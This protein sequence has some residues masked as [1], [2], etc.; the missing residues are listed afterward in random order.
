[1]INIKNETLQGLEIYLTTPGGPQ[2]YWLQPFEIVRVQREFI[3][4]QIQ[5]LASRRMVKLF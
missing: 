2:T 5:V 4:E 3:T 1:M